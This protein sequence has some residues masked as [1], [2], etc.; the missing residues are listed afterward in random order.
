MSTPDFDVTDDAVVQCPYPHY[1]AMRD[2][3]PVLELDGTPFGRAGER[4]FAVSRHEDVKRILHDPTTFSSRFGSPAAKPTG[5]LL[6]RDARARGNVHDFDVEAQPEG[7]LHPERRELAVA[8]HE[9]LVTG[10]SVLVIAASHAP[11]P[12]P[13]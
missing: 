1:R 3:A 6:E 4:L 11:V 5:E 8:C 10:F 13:G 7:H 9:H 12:E 2:E